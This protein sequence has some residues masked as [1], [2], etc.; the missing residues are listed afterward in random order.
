MIDP[1]RAGIRRQHTN[2]RSE[3]AHHRA[4]SEASAHPARRDCTASRSGVPAAPVHPPALTHPDR[5]NPQARATL[6]LLRRREAGPDGRRRRW[7]RQCHERHAS[8]QAPGQEHGPWG[9]GY[10]EP[11]R[12]DLDLILDSAPTTRGAVIHPH[13]KVIRTFMI[14]PMAPERSGCKGERSPSTEVRDRAYRAATAFPS[15][16]IGR[17]PFQLRTGERC[18][19]LKTT[20]G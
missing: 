16:R 12:A 13:E 7:L 11:G 19:K 2:A 14:E 4:V 10:K 15:A 20:C 3:M 9:G 1:R 18:A 8:V 17:R 5:P 6:P